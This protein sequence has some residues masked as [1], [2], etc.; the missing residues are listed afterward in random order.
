MKNNGGEFIQERPAE[1]RKCVD[2]CSCCE[3]CNFWR[4]NYG[5][6]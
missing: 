4:E 3:F 1:S 5:Q 6:G 2:Y